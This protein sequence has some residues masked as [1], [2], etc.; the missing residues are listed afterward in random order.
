[1]FGRI[2]NAQR[3]AFAPPLSERIDA[4]HAAFADDRG[5]LLVHYAT[6]QA[7]G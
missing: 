6:T 1:M 7:W 3:S 4:L 2:A 5:Q